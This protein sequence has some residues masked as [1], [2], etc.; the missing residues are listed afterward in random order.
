MSHIYRIGV[1]LILVLLSV[2]IMIV[3]E[4]DAVVQRTEGGVLETPAVIRDW[5]ILFYCN[6]DFRGS[7]VA[8]VFAQRVQ[9]REN[10]AVLMLEDTYDAEATLWHVEGGADSPVLVALEDWG[11]IDMGDDETLTRF[12]QFA[13]TWY[14]SRRTMVMLY[15]HGHGWR[16]VSYDDHPSADG[17]VDT[18]WLTPDEISAALLSV[19]GIDALLLTSP[20]NTGAMEFSYEVR[21]AVELFVASEAVSSFYV[22]KE[23]LPLILESLAS[24]PQLEIEAL[25]KDIPNWAQA[26]YDRE[27]WTDQLSQDKHHL[28]PTAVLSSAAGGDVMTVLAQALDVFSRTLIEALGD[29]GEQITQARMSSQSF[30]YQAFVDAYDLASNCASI[31]GMQE[32]SKALEAAT[33]GAVTYSVTD[34]NSHPR[35]HGL[36]LF[37]PMNS[38]RAMSDQSFHD[39]YGFGFY[40]EDYR[41]A[42]LDLLADTHWDEFLVAFY[43]ELLD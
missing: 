28:I 3:A 39:Q 30:A 40:E 15:S 7:N 25:A 37:F 20:C 5:A 14:P 29:Y 42:G 11:E 36:S 13:Q 12:L 35:A 10:V 32:A 17:S 24:D 31:P 2:S 19:G 22:W 1:A 38:D 16:G 18:T 23:S 4:E 6:A 43:E 8:D 33:L 9:S 21:N 41:T 27:F 26:T 34:P